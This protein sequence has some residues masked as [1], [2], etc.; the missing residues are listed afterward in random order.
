MIMFVFSHSAT[1]GKPQTD[2]SDNSTDIVNTVLQPH[3]DSV[4]S[5]CLNNFQKFLKE[6][7]QIK[8][9]YVIQESHHNNPGD[10]R[11]SDVKKENHKSIEKQAEEEKEQ[12]EQ[13][14]EQTGEE[15]EQT[16]EEKEQA[17]EEKE[18]TEQEKEQTGEEKEQTEQEKE[19]AEDEK[20]QTEQEK[21]QAEEEKEQTEQEKEQTEQ[22]KLQA[23]KDKEAEEA[24]EE[25]E[26]TEEEK[27]AEEEK[28]EEEKQKEEQAE[29][30]KQEAEEEKDEAEQEKVI[31]DRTPEKDITSKRHID[32]GASGKD[33]DLYVN[34][35]EEMAETQ[36]KTF[37]DNEE[38]TEKIKSCAFVDLVESCN[39]LK[40]RS[41]AC[42]GAVQMGDMSLVAN[43]C[44]KSTAELSH[45]EQDDV[46]V[47]V[48]SEQNS[49]VDY[50][51]VNMVSSTESPG[52]LG[53]LSS[54]YSEDS[55]EDNVTVLGNDTNNVLLGLDSATQLVCNVASHLPLTQTL[56]LTSQSQDDIA[57][58]M[59]TFDNNTTYVLKTNP[60]K[61]ALIDTCLE[62]ATGACDDSSQIITVQQT[63]VN[64]EVKKLLWFYLKKASIIISASLQIWN[65]KYMSI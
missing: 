9:Q 3:S 50:S 44:L 12:T 27:E 10:K 37:S 5:S 4:T 45:S 2:A 59:V 22:E 63:G 57:G 34:T 61:C 7:C 40:S 16:E 65:I 55:A 58:T 28:R 15:K 32:T 39:T 18:Q 51:N 43:T 54:V 20:E 46:H 8:R 31:R 29:V 52:E 25:K 24:E 47:G 11:Q 1:S 42:H 13:E 64:S 19:Q 41:E 56:Q 33:C 53:Q 36:M 35:V 60:A 21:E 26:Q 38:S 48:V 62:S 30:E 23:E 6:T 49:V 14:K 17:E